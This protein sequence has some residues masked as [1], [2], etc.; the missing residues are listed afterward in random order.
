M[1]K[2]DE[3]DNPVQSAL[4]ISNGRI[5]ATEPLLDASKHQSASTNL[6]YAVYDEHQA[7]ESSQRQSLPTAVVKIWIW[8]IF[9]IVLAII[10]IGGT[11]IFL[12]SYNGKPL[13][14]WPTGVTL[15]T[16]LSISSTVLRALIM[17]VLTEGIQHE[18]QL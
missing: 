17:V 10:V 15:N 18:A 7:T 14:E 16:V 9:S 6:T 12:H 2:T 1:Q 3:L 8:E 5:Q 11:V 13:P 4:E